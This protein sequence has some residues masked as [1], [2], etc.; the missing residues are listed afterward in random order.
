MKRLFTTQSKS[1]EALKSKIDMKRCFNTLFKA[2]NVNV[3][4]KLKSLQC[5]LSEVGTWDQP[6]VKVDINYFFKISIWNLGDSRDIVSHPEEMTMTAKTYLYS[7][8][9]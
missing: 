7:Y 5:T 6:H 9:I 2:E 1:L 8:F 3:A 4:A